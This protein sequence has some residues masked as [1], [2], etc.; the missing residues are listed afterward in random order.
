MSRK[1]EYIMA[2]AVLVLN[3]DYTPLGIVSWRDA[4]EKI[5]MGKAELIEKYPG[6]VLRSAKNSWAWPAVVRLTQKYVKQRVKLSR[7]NVLARD[8]YTCQ[9][10]GLQPRKSGG[11]PDFNVLTIDHVVPRFSAKKGKVS[12]YW[13][14]EKQVP[15]TCWENV[16]TAC[17]SCNIKKANK[18]LRHTSLRLRKFPEAPNMTE[19]VWIRFLG[20]AIPR[21]WEDYLPKDNPWVDYW[22]IELSAE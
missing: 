13:K 19:S 4:I 5:I 15:V 10:C 9:Y 1:K 3:I 6:R 16:V 14:K 12:L 21:E 18:D 20:A 17:S 22:R 2:D 7:K 11:Y 8:R